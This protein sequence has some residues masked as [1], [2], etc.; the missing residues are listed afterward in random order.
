[1]QIIVT[2][3]IKGGTGKTTTAAALAQ[4]ATKEGKKVLC[5]DLDAQADFSF[6]VAGDLTR[7]GAWGAL[8]GEA[9]PDLIQTTPQ[10]VDLIAGSSDLAT[11]TTANNSARRL[12]GAIEP[13]KRKYDFIF[14]D[15]P[16]QLGEL[17]FNALQ[18]ATGL[19]IP[20]EADNSS[21]QGLY[22]ITDLARAIRK[23]NPGLKNWGSVLTRY[24]QR[25]KIN[26]FLHDAIRDKAAEQGAPLLVSIRPGVAIREAQALQKSLFEYAPKSKPAQ[27]YERLFAAISGK[28]WQV[29]E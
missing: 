11:E 8:H 5:I 18:C 26:R 22:Q 1:M 12:Q 20:L 28:K 10:G 24:D 15:T 19:I 17:T 9:V 29:I 7:P 6:L 2:A 23:T 3:T 25:P 16:P 4:C 27:D 14:I 13:L 21:L